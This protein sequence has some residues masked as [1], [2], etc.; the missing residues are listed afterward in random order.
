MAKRETSA[1]ENGTNK[2]QN[3]NKKAIFLSLGTLPGS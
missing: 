2:K 3:I 1:K